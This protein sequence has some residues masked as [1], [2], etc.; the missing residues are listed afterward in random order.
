MNFPKWD[1]GSYLK[2][3]VFPLLCFLLMPQL[4]RAFLK[5]PENLF[6]E[7]PVPALS[8]VTKTQ[9]ASWAEVKRRLESR[10]QVSLQRRWDRLELK[11]DGFFFF[12]WSFYGH[13]R[14]IWKFPG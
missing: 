3:P 14:G 13:T 7:H 10:T 1:P 5:L 9:R 2:P 6:P 12:F 11:H 8:S 4:S